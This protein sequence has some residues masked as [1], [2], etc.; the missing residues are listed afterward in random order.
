MSID[1]VLKMVR[2]SQNKNK[3]LVYNF[4]II[5]YH[6]Y[7]IRRLFGYGSSMKVMKI[8]F[9]D[10]HPMIRTLVRKVLE[11]E[12]PLGLFE[13][14]KD[15]LALV[16]SIRCGN[17]DVAITDISMPVMNGLEA[18]RAIRSYSPTIPLVVLSSHTESRYTRLAFE[19][20]ASGF[21]DKYKMHEDLGN[22]IRKVLD[23]V[24][25]LNNFSL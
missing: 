18:I 7:I 6:A 13:E 15:G 12:F 17:W 1:P 25:A 19:A 10:D 4:Q 2:A 21:V 22:A 5:D 8:L 3:H 20:G 14:V 16:E 23:R 9:A 24:P 11:T